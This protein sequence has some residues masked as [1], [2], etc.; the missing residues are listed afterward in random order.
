MS[1]F[2]LVENKFTDMITVEEL[3]VFCHWVE[4]GEPL[5]H[6]MDIVPLHEATDANIVYSCLLSYKIY[7]DDRIYRYMDMEFDGVATFLEKKV[8]Y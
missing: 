3:S 5:K 8:V 4:D 7:L 2:S 6:F 1:T